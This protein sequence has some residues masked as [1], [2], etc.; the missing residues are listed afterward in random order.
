LGVPAT[1]LRNDL[2]LKARRPS[3]VTELSDDDMQKRNGACEQLLRVFETIP[4]REK[5]VFSDECATHRRAKRG[6]VYF[7][8]KENPHFFHELENKPTTRDDMG[9]NGCQSP[10]WPVFL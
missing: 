6:N 3:F 7:W 2:G 4:A 8:S 10:V 9:G 1:K 5:E